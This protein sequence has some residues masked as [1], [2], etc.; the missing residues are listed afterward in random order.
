[1]GQSIDQHVANV[2]DSPYS[3]VS[4]MRKDESPR[5]RTGVVAK[6]QGGTKNRQPLID[7]EITGG[8]ITSGWMCPLNQSRKIIRPCR[9]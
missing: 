1:M 7:D 5:L 8:H 4:K 6:R 3:L 9:R 2:I